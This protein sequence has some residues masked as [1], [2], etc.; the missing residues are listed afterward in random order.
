MGSNAFKWVASI[1]VALESE[2]E[3]LTRQLAGRVKE[4]EERY[5]SPLP[6]LEREV[7]EFGVKVE[8]H[9]KKMGL[10]L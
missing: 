3:R 9:L 2:V 4:L 5:A 8:G 6:E 7:E 10:S 1:R